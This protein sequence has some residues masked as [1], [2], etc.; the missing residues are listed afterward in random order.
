MT[1][2]LRLALVYGSAR[3]GRL[4]DVIAQ[5]AQ[6]R[7]ARHGGF[8][9]E[10]IDP[11]DWPL[12]G[13]IGPAQEARLHRLRERLHAADAFVLVTPEYNHGYPAALKALI[14]AC[15][16]PWRA[17]PVAF[18]SYGASSG[19]L[20]AIEQLRQVY[21]E[22]HAVTL[23]DCVSLAHARRQ[24]DDDG[25]LREPLAAHQAMSTL[26]TRLSWWATA[27]RDARNATPYEAAA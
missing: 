18:V 16:E 8:Q 15:Y 6:R 22:L 13:R 9:T 7:I 10:C 23:R 19:G 14:D 25:E 4:C 11:I 20:R 27:L 24:F 12:F 17:K 2:P 5:W 21:G 26:L 3:E 1:S